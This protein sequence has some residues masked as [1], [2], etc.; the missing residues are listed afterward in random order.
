MGMA[1][2]QGHDFDQGL[3]DAYQ[4]IA[5]AREIDATPVL[6][7]GYYTIG[8]THTTMGSLDKGRDEINLAI[9]FS[10][11]GSDVL[12]Q[13]LA[14]RMAGTLKNWEADYAEAVHLLSESLRIAREHH[15]L[16]PLLFGFFIYGV[17]L[18]GK[19]DYDE[20][21]AT[22]EEGLALSEKLGDEVQRHR[23][24]NSSGWLYA[25]LG[26][27]SRALDLNWQAAEMA[28]KRG[29]PETIANAEL[30]LGDIFLAHGDLALAQEFLDGV[31][32]LVHNPATS[33]WAKWRYS[34]HLFASLG[35][36]WLARG[37]PARAQ[38]FAAQC[39]DI[40]TRTNSR[41]Y[42]VKGWRLLG[43]MALA[44]RQWDEAVG[45]LQQ[46]LPLAQAVGN[47]TQLW[48]THLALGRLHAEARQPEQAQ[49]AYR[50]ARAVIER[51]KASL[52]HPEL[53]A[54]LEHSP[55]IQQIYDLSASS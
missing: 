19:G 23:L 5:I 34:M 38:E 7:G 41:K 40:A 37:E 32:R 2:T 8:F 20:A 35:D 45:W 44:R 52:Q 4:A 27:L 12:H 13:S 1:S 36:F 48:K 18:T 30:N 14:L 46:A 43:E 17:A 42:L 9:T 11:S 33:D 24:L 51:V 16:V 28:R 39:L 47:P 25:E 15:L 21:R 10:Q 26:N 6:A 31:Y 54:S 29:D 3:A 50:T 49:Q 53:C 22:F 55:L